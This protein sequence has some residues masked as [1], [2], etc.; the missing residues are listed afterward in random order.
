MIHIIQDYTTQYGRAMIHEEKHACQM[1]GSHVLWERSSIYQH[2]Y[3]AGN[4]NTDDGFANVDLSQQLFL[5]SSEGVI[6]IGLVTRIQRF[7]LCPT[8]QLCLSILG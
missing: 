2:I 8:Y 5:S 4:I 3:Q 6:E 1:C 7:F